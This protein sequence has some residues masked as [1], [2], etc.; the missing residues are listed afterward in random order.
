M[1]DDQLPKTKGGDLGLL[2]DDDEFEEFPHENW[3]ESQEDKGDINVWEDNWDDDTVEDDF[4]VQ[5]S[6]YSR[7]RTLPHSPPVRSPSPASKKVCRGRSP[8]N[9]EASPAKQTNG[10]SRNSRSSSRKTMYHILRLL[11]PALVPG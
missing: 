6:K 2:E 4:S 7:K 10:K 1:S 8:A 11:L 9:V 3:D 5:L